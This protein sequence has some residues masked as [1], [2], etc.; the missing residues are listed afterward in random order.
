[1]KLCGLEAI[2]TW[3]WN[4]SPIFGSGA[5]LRRSIPTFN[6]GFGD[7][8]PPFTKLLLFKLIFKDADIRSAISDLLLDE[9]KGDVGSSI[10]SGV[11]KI[12]LI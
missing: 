1:M 5:I 6:D 4:N 9:N 12:M 7:R 11:L 3:S 8:N 10:I 2:V